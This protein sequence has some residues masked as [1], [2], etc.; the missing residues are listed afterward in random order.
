MIA[1]SLRTFVS[2]GGMQVCKEGNAPTRARPP[3]H[4]EKV[5]R[6]G[7][8][9]AVDGLHDVLEDVQ[10]RQGANAAAVQRED[11]EFALRHRSSIRYYYSVGYCEY[12]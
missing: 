2:S 3:D 6:L 11:V 9:L 7:R 10:G 4:I 5:A 1:S 8:V 12:W